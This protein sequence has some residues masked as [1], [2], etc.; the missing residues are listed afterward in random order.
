MFY[1]L[2]RFLERFQVYLGLRKGQQACNVNVRVSDGHWQTESG[3]ALCNYCCVDGCLMP[4]NRSRVWKAECC[5]SRCHESISS[6]QACWDESFHYLQSS[7]Y[8]PYLSQYYGIH[9][10]KFSQTRVAAEWKLLSCYAIWP[11]KKKKKEI[12]D[13]FRNYLVLVWNP[14]WGKERKSCKKWNWGEEKSQIFK[15]YRII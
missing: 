1:L 4:E 13:R 12:K 6:S 7:G 10:N 14:K 2:W 11:K 8:T 3:D 9:Q 5:S 15:S